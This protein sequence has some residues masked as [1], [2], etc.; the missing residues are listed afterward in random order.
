[1]IQTPTNPLTTSKFTKME[2]DLLKDLVEANPNMSWKEISEFFE[3]HTP[4]QLRNRWENYLGPLD[5]APKWTEC[6]DFAL[7]DAVTKYGTQWD[8]VAHL[9]ANRS[10]NDIKNRYNILMKKDPSEESLSNFQ[11]NEYGIQQSFPNY[12]TIQKLPGLQSIQSLQ[13]ND[14][15]S[16]SSFNAFA[17]SFPQ[18]LNRL[19]HYNN[20]NTSED[21][22]IGTFQKEMA[23][24]KIGPKLA[25]LKQKS[26]PVCQTQRPKVIIYANMA[27][28]KKMMTEMRLST[29]LTNTVK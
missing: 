3:R 28:A 8:R 6:D 12:Q 1:M 18:T 11:D 9:M 25:Q 4:R 20:N 22:D 2:D 7:L 14:T 15:Y 29:A 5:R 27:S 16:S 13:L 19:N 23:M 17:N 10:I 24:I 21:E 26:K